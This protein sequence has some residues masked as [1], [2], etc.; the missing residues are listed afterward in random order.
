MMQLF[1]DDLLN[2]ARQTVDELRVAGKR[3][4]TAK[5]CT[6]GL[7][8]GLLTEISGS[9]DVLGRGFV[10][11]SND[12]KNQVLGVSTE[13]LRLYGAVSAETVRELVAGTLRACGDDA[14]IAVAVSGIAGPGGGTPTKPVGTV[15]VGLAEHHKD[16]VA[17]HLLIPGDRT[18]VR[19]ATAKAAL[20]MVRGALTTRTC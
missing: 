4:A 14:D 17:R 5:S 7:I 20:E 18:T 12:A 2:L 8:A 19:L 15:Y 3:V 16:P 1:P 11:Y 10:V 9:S 13:T 6:G